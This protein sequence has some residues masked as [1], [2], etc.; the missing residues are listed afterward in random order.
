MINNVTEQALRESEEKYRTLVENF[1]NGAVGLF[2]RNLRYTAVGGEL[3]NAVGLDPQER[4]GNKITDIYPE[5]IVEELLPHFRATLDG[6]ATSFEAEFHDRKLLAQTLPIKNGEEEI[7]SGMLVV[8]DI[9]ERWTAQQALRK[10][11]EKYRTLFE[12]MDEGFC[13]LKLEFDANDEVTDFRYEEINPSFKKH[14]GLKDVEGKKGS[15]VLGDLEKDWVKLCGQVVLT[16]ESKNYESYSETLDRWFEVSALPVGKPE[17]Q[18]VAALFNNITERKRAQE[19]L[20]AMNLNLEKQVKERTK[21]LVSYQNK[22]R[23]LVAELSRAEEQERQ[24]L[25]SDLHDNLGQM[26]AVGKM[27]ISQV[28]KD[29]L[30]DSEAKNLDELAALIDDAVTYTRELTS[31]L[32]P[33]ASLDVEDLKA[34]IKWVAEKMK[35]HNLEVTIKDDERPKPLDKEVRITLLQCVRELLFN[36]VKHASVKEAVVFITRHHDYIQISVQDEG[37][38][39]DPE[40]KELTPDQEG[41]FGLFSIRERVDTLGGRMDLDSE[42]GKGTKV[43]LYL[44]LKDR[45]NH[46]APPHRDRWPKQEKPEMTKILLADKPHMMREILQTAIENEDDMTVIGVADD[47]KEAVKKAGSLSPDIILMEANL[48]KMNGIEATINILAE[49]AHIR[50]IGFSEQDN[51]KISQNMRKAGASSFISKK[52]SFKSLT[53][54]IRAEAS[55]QK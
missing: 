43:S 41:G 36:I 26:L 42:P 17:E 2:D 5:E 1:P 18:K 19:K 52:E 38:G 35:K 24:R 7:I 9:T 21:S 48:P 27:K 14:S 49:D 40:D 20:K 44:P 33:P 13:I 50:I 54:S 30:P 39:F 15:Q 10:S 4:I 34:H 22:L 23:S 55:A 53:S 25:A 51:Q 12:T 37:E 16:G 8:Q 32:K 11:E 46:E 31:E 6:E 29:K 47:G 45:R 28:Q 3:L